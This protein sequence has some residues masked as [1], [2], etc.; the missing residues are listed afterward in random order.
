MQVCDTD[1]GCVEPRRERPAVL[2]P[3]PA[4]IGRGSVEHLRHSL[5]DIANVRAGYSEDGNRV[6]LCG[7][8]VSTADERGE[9]V[10]IEDDDG[11]GHV[12]SV[13]GL[14]LPGF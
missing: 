9:Y 11:T 14:I 13:A 2:A 12:V 7:E 6:E 5:Q 4:D 8:I 3:L 10:V 1:P